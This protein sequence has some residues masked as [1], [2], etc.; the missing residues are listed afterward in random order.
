MAERK[1]S[2]EKKKMG[3]QDCSAAMGQEMTEDDLIRVGA[4]ILN[5]EMAFKLCRTNFDRKDD[6]PLPKELEEAIP[7]G[8]IVVWKIGNK[9]WD[10]L[11]DEYY[12]MNN[13]DK[14]TSF[15]T[16]KCLEDLALKEIADYHEKICK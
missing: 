13:W 15:P 16:K 12:E 7:T 1:G 9:N 10:N 6:Y 14:K 8:K 2:H 5:V 4:R 11:L 3:S